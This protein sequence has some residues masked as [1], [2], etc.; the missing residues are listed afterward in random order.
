MLAYQ[1]MFSAEVVVTRQIQSERG[2]KWLQLGGGEERRGRQL[3]ISKRV[4]CT[5]HG[6]KT[7]KC[8][9]SE[10]VCCGPCPK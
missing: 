1:M 9:S 8:P 10:Q 5:W 3:S 4:L 2:A 6:V 7:K